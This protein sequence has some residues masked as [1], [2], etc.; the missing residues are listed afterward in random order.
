[1]NPNEGVVPQGR[2]V[3]MA[4]QNCSLQ[5][6]KKGVLC[7]RKGS[8]DSRP[9]ARKIFVDFKASLVFEIKRVEGKEETPILLTAKKKRSLKKRDLGFGAGLPVRFCTELGGKKKE[10]KR[11]INNRTHHFGKR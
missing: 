4:E 7:T 3:G 9:P 6:G 8:G 1:V 5:K 10:K 11:I 2:R